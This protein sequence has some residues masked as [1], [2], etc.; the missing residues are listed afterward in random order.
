MIFKAVIKMYKQIVKYF[1]CCILPV[2]L[3]FA[4]ESGIKK[5]YPDNNIDL[6]K[7]GIRVNKDLINKSVSSSS[8]K[9]KTTATIDEQG[10]LLLSVLKDNLNIN[11]KES[12]KPSLFDFFGK[13]SSRNSHQR[14]E[15]NLIT[16]FSENI[17]IGSISGKFAVI[18][19][20][21]KLRIEP[22]EFIS[23][24]ANQNVRYLI[25]IKT[26]G[27][28]LK[29]LVVQSAYILAIDNFMSLMFKTQTITQSV[30]GFIA[31]N[32]ISALV[33]TFIDNNS[34]YKTYSITSY[35]YSIKIRL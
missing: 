21:P 10:N 23:I 26:A 12:V 25:P 8:E 1:L 3:L 35:Q 22:V 31:K 2:N 20:T 33:G 6:N 7:S 9:I 4:Q 17:D 16:S 15:K 14:P 28:H 34:K 18:S 19:F 24:S 13:K 27:Q 30:A 32:F 11:K 5:D 29:L